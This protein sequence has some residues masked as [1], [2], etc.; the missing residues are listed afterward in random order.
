MRARTKPVEIEF[1]LWSGDNLFEVITFTD[2]KP[3]II[4]MYA[5]QMWEDYERLVKKDGLKIYT[6]EGK[7]SAAIG[8][9]IVKGLTGGFYPCNPIAFALK[10]E[11]IE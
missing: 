5:G 11:I 3:D 4:A 7:M 1:V 6:P 9:Y 8:D 2:G 10:Y